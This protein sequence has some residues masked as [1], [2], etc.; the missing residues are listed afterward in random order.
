MADDNYLDIETL[1][2]QVTALENGEDL[3]MDVETF[4]NSLD[5]VDNIEDLYICVESLPK[6]QSKAKKLVEAFADEDIYLKPDT[7]GTQEWHDQLAVKLN[8]G[9]ESWYYGPVS[10]DKAERL[11]L[12]QSYGRFLVRVSIKKNKKSY[13]VTVS[14][15]KL[16]F[17]HIAVNVTP[18]NK[19]VVDGKAFADVRAVV[20]HFS[21]NEYN[22]IVKLQGSII[23]KARKKGGAVA[24]G[25]AA[26]PPPPRRSRPSMDAAAAG[27]AEEAP[28]VPARP[29]MAGASFDFNSDHIYASTLSD[30]DEDVDDVYEAPVVGQEN[31]YMEAKVQP[32]GRSPQRAA[33]VKQQPLPKDVLSWTAGEVQ[34]WLKDKNIPEFKKPFYANGVDGT[35]LLQLKGSQFPARRF[36][37]DVRDRLDAEIAKLKKTHTPSQSRGR[38]SSAGAGGDAPPPPPP[39]PSLSV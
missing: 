36:S 30:D 33:T 1:K 34:R 23:P 29:S 37:Q 5:Q 14:M 24:D 13:A 11:V 16:Q 25:G 2:Q 3:Y 31:L 39:R 26:P 20:K 22:G 32:P 15:G 19:C 28:A 8:L 35:M 12:D 7:S 6:E 17:L 9:T 10:R 4:T 27:A 18:D 21:A 38:K